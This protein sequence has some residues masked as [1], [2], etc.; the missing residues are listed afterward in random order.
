ME[1]SGELPDF[2]RWDDT[3]LVRRGFLRWFVR[4]ED[5]PV[6]LT[7]ID[8]LDCEAL[9]AMD[10]TAIVEVAT[11]LATDSDVLYRFYRQMKDCFAQEAT[12]S[13]I[14]MAVPY[15]TAYLLMRTECQARTAGVS[16][17]LP[18]LN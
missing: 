12:V 14:T 3:S 18:Y 10:D 13:Q 4:R 7:E 17:E 8:R 1:N 6:Y 11:Q 16:L 15:A 2:C 5:I 9:K